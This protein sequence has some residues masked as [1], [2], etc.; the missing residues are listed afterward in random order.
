MEGPFLVVSKSKMTRKRGS[1]FAPVC[2]GGRGGLGFSSTGQLF[3]Q[4]APEVRPFQI[5]LATSMCVTQASSLGHPSPRWPQEKV[6]DPQLGLEVSECP[7][8]L[9]FQLHLLSSLP[10][11]SVLQPGV[12]SQSASSRPCQ[13]SLS[14]SL[15]FFSVSPFPEACDS[16]MG[17]F[18]SPGDTW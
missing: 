10:S 6:P 4:K 8:F 11:G 15:L 14:C 5:P 2:S 13:C 17:D 9:L 16:Q 3:L 18:I 12:A 1:D 7:G